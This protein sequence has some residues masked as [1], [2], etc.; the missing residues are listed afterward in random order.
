MTANAIVGLEASADFGAVLLATHTRPLREIFPLRR[1]WLV[2]DALGFRDGAALAQALTA[3]PGVTFAEA[4]LLVPR[5]PAMMPVPPDDP[6]YPGQWYLKHIDIEGAWKL[7]TGSSSVT[8]QVI[9]NGCDTTH[10]DLAPH[11]LQG[12]NALDGGSDPQVTETGQG[13]G[14][15]TAC[16]GIVGAVGNNDAGIAGT[17]PEC[18]VRCVRMLDKSGISIPVSAD[19]DAMRFALLHDDVAVISNSWAFTTP[20]PVPTG[21]KMAIQDVSHLAHG[22]K[23]ALVVFAAGNE[24]RM[25]QAGELY[26]LPEVVTVA[27][28]SNF[29]ETAPYSNYGP[30]VDVSAPTGSLTLDPVGASGDTPDDYTT[31]FGGTSSAC[32]VVAGVAGLL[33]AAKPSA[34]ADEVRD[35]LVS[36]ARKAPY[37]TPDMNGHDDHYGYGIV[38]PKAALEKLLGIVPDAG[39]PDAGTTDAGESPVAPPK[40]CGCA[41]S[42]PLVLWLAALAVLFRSRA[43]KRPAP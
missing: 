1:M 32:P 2:T 5:T 8:I 29:D 4:D 18:M 14:H 20:M 40:G 36:T 9:D 13:S 42:G 7:S 11:L 31:L 17:C 35:A 10:P 33:F 23:G 25:L 43:L 6:L 22:G 3:Q 30:D 15:G 12:F 21:L 28:V 26:S 38:D 24:N 16:A 37:A 41:A 39:V 19:V 34:T 27:A